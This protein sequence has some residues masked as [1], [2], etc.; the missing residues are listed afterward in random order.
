[1]FQRLRAGLQDISNSPVAIKTPDKTTTEY[2]DK[3]CNQI[4]KA[5][6]LFSGTPSLPPSTL[7]TDWSLKTKVRF[8][9]PFPFS[10]TQSLRP[11]QEASGLS[12]F[13][14]N[15]HHHTSTGTSDRHVDLTESLMVWLHPSL[16]F[17]KTFPR[18]VAETQAKSSLP[19]PP[20]LQDPQI[21]QSLKDDWYVVE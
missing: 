21:L 18:H 9:S 1:M 16:P 10:W 12:Q 13:L 15:H 5:P 2:D 11:H 6:L 14:T 8:V 7:P 19:P 20:L 17:L 4:Y 3:P